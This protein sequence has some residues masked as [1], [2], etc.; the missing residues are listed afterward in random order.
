ME[1][2]FLSNKYF[3][4]DCHTQLFQSNSDVLSDILKIKFKKLYI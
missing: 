3:D 2:Q 4:I 1:F